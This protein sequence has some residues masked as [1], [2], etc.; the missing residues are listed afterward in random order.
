[1]SFT[2]A[3]LPMSMRCNSCCFH[4]KTLKEIGEISSLHTLSLKPNSCLIV[5][6]RAILGC[7]L[8]AHTSHGMSNTAWVRSDRAPWLRNAALSWFG[9]GWQMF[10]WALRSIIC[11]SLD[12]ARKRFPGVDEWNGSISVSDS[13][14]LFTIWLSK[15][16]E[17]CSNSCCSAF[18]IWQMSGGHCGASLDAGSCGW[19]G[20]SGRDGSCSSISWLGNGLAFMLGFA[21]L[22]AKTVIFTLHGCSLRMTCLL[23]RQSYFSQ[24]LWTVTFP[25]PRDFM[26]ALLKGA[27]F[28][29]IFSGGPSVRSVPLQATIPLM[30]LS[31]NKLW[32]MLTMLFCWMNC[33]PTRGSDV[34][35]SFMMFSSWL[36]NVTSE[37]VWL[38]ISDG[39]SFR[40]FCGSWLSS[41]LP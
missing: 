14:S 17:G 8:N 27:S 38:E 28:G 3:V 29:L 13:A 18:W 9:L 2:M 33:F 23:A 20:T 41:D 35:I 37:G 12:S 7:C 32:I 39:C 36:R 19:D 4:I 11:S 10:W 40:L 5:Q 31:G 24:S 16:L 15:F 25:L 1:M 22:P 34:S 21:G 30:T 26:M 6:G